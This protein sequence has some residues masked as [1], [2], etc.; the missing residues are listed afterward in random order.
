MVSRSIRY[1]VTLN[2]VTNE[3]GQYYIKIK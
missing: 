1:I 2:S 3:L